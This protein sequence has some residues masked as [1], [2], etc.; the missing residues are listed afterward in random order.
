MTKGESLQ[1]NETSSEKSAA[2][3]YD[4]IRTVVGI[5]KKNGWDLESLG[6]IEKDLPPAKPVTLTRKQVLERNRQVKGILKRFSRILTPPVPTDLEQSLRKKKHDALLPWEE[7]VL[8]KASKWRTQ[9]KKA[10]PEILQELR[11]AILP[12]PEF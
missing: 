10:K 2:V 7:E 4:Y 8:E 1:Q 5:A 9:V 3:N 11:R 6:L 12:D